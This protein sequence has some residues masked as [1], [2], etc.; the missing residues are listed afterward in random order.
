[1]RLGVFTQH[2]LDSFDLRLTALENMQKRFPSALDSELRAHLGRFE[3]H[4][5]DA[6]KPLKFT[7]GGQKSRVAFAC[8]TFLRPHVIVLDEPTNHLD[9]TAIEALIDA[10]KKFTGGILVVSH[11][12]HFISSVCNEI[13]VLGNQSIKRL[14]GDI[15]TY[16]AMVI[17]E[18]REKK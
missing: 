7:S 2:H 18:I 3:L 15:N 6:L 13:W 5:S 12:Q 8:L 17:K 4:G 11:D 10:L 9:M 14:N 16:K 1:M